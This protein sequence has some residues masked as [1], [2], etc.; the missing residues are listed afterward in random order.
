VD[1]PWFNLTMGAV[2]ALNA[3]CIGLEADALADKKVGGPETRMN[4]WDNNYRS[5][6]G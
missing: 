5:W 3:L 1:K 4:W 6:S 2:I